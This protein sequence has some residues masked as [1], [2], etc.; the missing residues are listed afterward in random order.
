MAGY[1]SGAH[2]ISIYM[3]PFQCIC[4]DVQK[5]ELTETDN[6]RLFAANGKRK[7]QTFVCFLQTEKRK[8]QVCLH[9]S[10]NDKRQSRFAVSANVP[11][12]DNTDLLNN[13]YV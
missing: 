11:S 8:T 3:L 10:A 5:T 2:C 7:W 6:F 13:R 9:W 1:T 12:Y 4:I